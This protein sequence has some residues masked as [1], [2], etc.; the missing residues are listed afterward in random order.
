M[1]ICAALPLLLLLLMPNEMPPVCPYVP[2]P[3][4]KPSRSSSRAFPFGAGA[5]GA[6]VDEPPCAAGVSS[7]G[8][9]KSIRDNSLSG[10]ALTPAPLVPSVPLGIFEAPSMSPFLISL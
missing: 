1:D 2:P 10:P 3:I 5:E 8:P 7:S 6:A 9:P 4:D